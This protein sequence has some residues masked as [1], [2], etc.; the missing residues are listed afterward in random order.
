M[1]IALDLFKMLIGE[2]WWDLQGDDPGWPWFDPSQRV[3]P[4]ISVN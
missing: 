4:A 1:G 3:W 2:C